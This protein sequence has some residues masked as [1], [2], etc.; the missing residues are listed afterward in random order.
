V[1]LGPRVQIYTATHP[2]DAGE[3]DRGLESAEP[4]TIG[5]RVWIGGEA[6]ISP[7]VTIGDR[8]TIGS[9]SVVTRDI[10][11]NVFADG[12]PCRVVRTPH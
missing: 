7:G 12:N 5:E 8:S 1:L 4:V 10:P 3:R 9:G 6:I 2:L 11:P